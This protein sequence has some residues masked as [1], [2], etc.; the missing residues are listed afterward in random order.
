MISIFQI[1]IATVPT[2]SDIKNHYQGINQCCGNG[3]AIANFGTGVQ[4]SRVLSYGQNSKGLTN[5][6]K[7]PLQNSFSD[8]VKNASLTYI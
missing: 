2:C 5:Y 7:G 8:Y 4:N 1:M 3:N 6:P